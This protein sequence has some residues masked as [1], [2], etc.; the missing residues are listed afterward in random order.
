MTGSAPHALLP[1]D[2]DTLR[3]AAALPHD[4][5]DRA[6]ACLREQLRVMSDA[7]GAA[8]DWTTLT[9]TGPVEMPGADPAAR[10]E[11]TACVVVAPSSA[12][13][14]AGRTLPTTEPAVRGA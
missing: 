10:F 1:D 9:V 2:A 12:P 4:D 13:A 5:R 6:L 7:A 14:R 8:P 3:A 11:W